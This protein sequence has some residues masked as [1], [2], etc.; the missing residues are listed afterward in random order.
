MNL[1]KHLRLLSAQSYFKLVIKIK[2]KTCKDSFTHL[3]FIKIIPPNE[4]LFEY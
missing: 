4:R 1:G 2:N 3:M